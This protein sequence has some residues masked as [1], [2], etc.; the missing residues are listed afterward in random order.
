MSD[1]IRFWADDAKIEAKK[2]PEVSREEQNDL[3]LFS[4]ADPLKEPTYESIAQQQE[5]VSEVSSATTLPGLIIE[6]TP[7][8]AAVLKASLDQFTNADVFDFDLE[9]DARDV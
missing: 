4:S 8:E 6:H 2:Q 7:D 9:A 3:A 5:T 1:A